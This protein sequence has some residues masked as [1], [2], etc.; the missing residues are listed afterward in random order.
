MKTLIQYINEGILGDIDDTMKAGD[1][2]SNSIDY[3][4]KSITNKILDESNWNKLKSNNQPVYQFEIKIPLICKL[5]NQKGSGK[6]LFI[7]IEHNQRIGIWSGCLMLCDEKH[8]FRGAIDIYRTWSE[9]KY[10]NFEELLKNTIV[11]MLKDIDTLSSELKI[12]RKFNN[13]EYKEEV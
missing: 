12:Y 4:L 3:E 11:P 5:L 7:S 13:K 9:K 2:F 10:K 8:S 6:N 1:D